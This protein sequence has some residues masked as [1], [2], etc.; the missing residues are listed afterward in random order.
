MPVGEPEGVEVV[1]G[2]LDLAAVDDLVAEAEEDVLDVPP[3]LRRR[4]ERA[5]ASRADRAEQLG[6]QRDIDGLRREPRVELLA[7]ELLLARGERPLDRLAGG[8][9]G[10]ARLAVAHLSERELQ[11]GLAAEV[12]DV[13]LFELAGRRRGVDRRNRLAL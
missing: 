3:H 10:H 9:Q 8:V 12:L 7:L 13:K 2:G 5:A 1:A 6:R 11:V 4:M